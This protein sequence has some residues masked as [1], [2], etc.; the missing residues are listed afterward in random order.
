MTESN[1]FVTLVANDGTS[2][3]VELQVAK[4][5]Q[6]ITLLIEDAGIEN[7]IPLK[8]VSGKALCKI[9]E[10]CK[11]HVA[12][13]VTEA[14]KGPNAVIVDW[15]LSFTKDFDQE[16]LFEL[17]CAA[18][19]LHVGSLVDLIAKTIANMIKGKTPEQIR[20]IF[21]IENDFTA[22]EEQKIRDEN[23]WIEETAQ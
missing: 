21:N 20:E 18:N 6:A 2:Y 9:I 5:S 10:Y 22:E 19:W 17:L 1:D 11:Y 16:M 8:E 4:E 23:K 7:P 3:K 15:D 14:Q 12:N 13:P